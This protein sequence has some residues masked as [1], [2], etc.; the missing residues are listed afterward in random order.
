MKREEYLQILTDQIRCRMARDAVK[1]EYC[2]HIEDQMQDFMSEG[3]DRKEA[4]KAA[5]KEMGDPVETGNELDRIHRPVMPWGMIALVAALSI[6]GFVIQMTM[7]GKVETAGGYGWMSISR[8]LFFMI[9]G[10][11]VMMAVCFADYTRIARHARFLMI[12]FDAGMLAALLV[13]FTINGVTNYVD[14]PII[15]YITVEY[16]MLLTVPLYAAVLYAYRG[17]GYRAIGKAVLWMLV[18]VVLTFRIP[19]FTTACI[20]LFSFMAVLAAAVWKGW[21]R[22]AKKG[23]FAGIL[24]CI[25]CLPAAL[26]AWLWF[27]GAEYQQERVQAIL[28]D[29][30][31]GPGA[32]GYVVQVVREFLDS[33]RIAGAG[34]ADADVLR[35]PEVSEFALTGVIA[36]YGI[37]A[38]AVLAG[39]LLF[40][41]F[42]F[43]KISLRQRNQLGMLMGTACSI[44]FLLETAGYIVTNL[45]V[46]YIG[47]FCPF[48]SYGGTGTIVTYVLLGLLLSIC[49]Y[50][51]TAPEREAA[52]NIFPF[53]AAAPAAKIT[54]KKTDR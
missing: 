10:L 7:Q 42:R 11:A 37:L 43:L 33:S 16:L 17:Q 1:E 9:I 27:F 18:P 24:A 41:L 22:V 45:G 44:L 49:R 2:A 26:F 54:D 19:R 4:E 12:L 36:Y 8:N 6:I 51:R 38:A 3:M 50:T 35:I 29:P 52:G 15:G 20:L 30:N 46:S 23:T 13:G 34:A 5:V 28:R 53:R 31:Q 48:L 32:G 39:L 25:F 47:V 21:F 40:L 14:I